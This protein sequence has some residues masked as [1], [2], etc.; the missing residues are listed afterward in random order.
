M[1]FITCFTVAMFASSCGLLE[2]D[3][4]ATGSCEMEVA[5]TD[6][7]SF[8]YCWEAKDFKDDQESDFEQLC[9][10]TNSSDL[11]VTGSYSKGKECSRVGALDYTCNQ[12]YAEASLTYVF[13]LPFTEAQAEEI[14]NS[15]SSALR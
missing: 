12:T 11:G 15:T 2:E 8:N 13:Y 7:V 4:K 6:S 5:I 9:S 10:L 1:R 14:C 3:K